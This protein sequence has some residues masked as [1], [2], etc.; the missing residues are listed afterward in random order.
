LV[1]HG[2]YNTPEDLMLDKS[3][4]DKEKIDMLKKWR[5]D[6]K[7]LLR[8]SSEGMQGDDRPDILKQVKKALISLQKTT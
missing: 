4:S 1:Y 8:A 7:S 6:E 5:D 3:L 2:K